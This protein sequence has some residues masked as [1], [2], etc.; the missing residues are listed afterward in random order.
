MISGYVKASGSATSPTVRDGSGIRKH[1]GGR[2]KSAG[3]VTD[4]NDMDRGE[5]GVFGERMTAIACGV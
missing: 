4:I 5:K 1:S 3:I 2:P